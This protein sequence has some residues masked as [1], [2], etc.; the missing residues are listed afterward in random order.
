MRDIRDRDLPPDHDAFVAARP[1]RGRVI[2]IAPTRAACETIELA[3]TLNLQT[4]L[5]KNHGARLRELAASGRGFGIVAGTGTGKTLAVR[6]IA[7]TILGEALR[8]GVINREREATP[9]T[10]QWNV[11]IARHGHRGR[12]PPDLGRAR[13][14]PGTGQARAVSLHLALGHRRSIVLLG[15]PRQR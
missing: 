6:P 3:F 11:I 2:I 12:D 14:L 13:T 5:E 9:D 15:V 10:P 1:A 7:E 4:Y 8:V